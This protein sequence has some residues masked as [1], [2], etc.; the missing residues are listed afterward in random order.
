M[1]RWRFKVMAG[2]NIIDFSMPTGMLGHRKVKARSRPAPDEFDGALTRLQP[3]DLTAPTPSLEVAPDLVKAIYSV[4][5]DL[6]K[7]HQAIRALFASKLG[8]LETTAASIQQLRT[9]LNTRCLSLIEANRL[10]AEINALELELETIR[11]GAKWHAYVN[12]VQGILEA[13]TNLASDEVRGIVKFVGVAEDEIEDPIKVAY[14]HHLIREYLNIADKYISLD[15]LWEVTQ[16]LKCPACRCSLLDALVDDEGLILCSCGFQQPNLVKRS[17]FKDAMRVNV[18]GRS[19][20]EDRTTFIKAFDRFMGSKIPKIPDRLY[21]ML[22]EYFTRE[23]FP[24]G[25]TIKATFPLLPN[26]KRPMTSVD[27]MARALSATSNT[28]YYDY[29]NSIAFHYWGWNL[30]DL[31]L[32]REIIIND[33]DLS[34]KVYEEIRER[35]SSLNVQIR[36]YAHL[37]ARGYPCELSDFKILTSRESLEYHNRM[38]QVMFDR[39]GLPRIPLI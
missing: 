38:L 36:L 15:I 33:Y 22:D 18:G 26:G 37:L 2:E 24:L 19:G 29:I 32:M 28:S 16:D 5:L 10:A 21:E 17:T 39:I 34:Q 23:G 35:G 11:N 4:D 7:I 12:Q 30:P 3:I 14:R 25:S 1:Q 8:H 20:Y 27:L 31:S 13:Y 9:M 6:F